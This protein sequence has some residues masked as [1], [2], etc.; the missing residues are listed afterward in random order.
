MA[1]KRKPRRNRKRN[2][3]TRSLISQHV[4]PNNLIMKHR[5]VE[6]I[7]LSPG[8]L[9][10]SSF[11]FRANDVYD[12]S[13]TTTGHQPLGYDEMSSM[14]KHFTVLGSKCSVLAASVSTEAGPSSAIGTYISGSST[15]ATTYD[16]IVEQGQGRRRLLAG[17]SGIANLRTNFSTKKYFG[18]KP[19]GL[20]L[21]RGVSGN[22]GTGSSPSE[23]AFFIVWAQSM[24][25][26]AVSPINLQ[27]QIDYIVQWAERKQFVQS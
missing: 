15:V 19:A 11:V 4:I 12:P 17:G 16:T 5:Y 27:V 18:V 22:F 25:T 10:A 21:Y 8:A 1:R 3:G 2:M 26:G 9:T 13:V 14:Y 6:T 24:T 20:S 23:Q 7:V